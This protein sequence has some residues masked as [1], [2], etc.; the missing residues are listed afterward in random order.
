IHSNCDAGCLV[1]GIKAQSEQQ[2]KQAEALTPSTTHSTLQEKNKPE[3][4]RFQFQKIS[5]IT[6]ITYNLL[7]G[8]WS[9]HYFVLQQHNP[10]PKLK[11]ICDLACTHFCLVLQ[12]VI[13]QRAR[14]EFC[15]TAIQLCLCL[16]FVP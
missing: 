3:P 14:E 7:V 13:Q 5:S 1:Y 6:I 2:K 4:Q 10:D 16:V 12:Y 9:Q 11:Y 15:F 8:L